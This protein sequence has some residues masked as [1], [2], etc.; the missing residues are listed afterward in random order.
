VQRGTND[1]GGRGVEALE[2]PYVYPAQQADI[3][4]HAELIG[5]P[6]EI[7]LVS[8]RISRDNEQ[9]P[10]FFGDDRDRTDQPQ[11]ILVGA[12]CRDAER[13]RSGPG[14]ERSPED[15]LGHRHRLLPQPK[16]LMHDVDLGRRDPRQPAD[17]VLDALCGDDDAVRATAGERN[18][19]PHADPAQPEMC[20]RRDPVVKI[21]NRHDPSEASPD[22]RRIRQAV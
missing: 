12:L 17:V 15:M 5:A 1:A 6:A 19:D 10:T 7:V 14:L 20:L 3:A 2:L 11:K 4:A 16:P 8:C 21:V 9:R 13:D 22:G 18:Q